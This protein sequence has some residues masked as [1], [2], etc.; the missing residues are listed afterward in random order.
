V[1]YEDYGY[2]NANRSCINQYLTVPLLEVLKD[3]P[4]STIIDLGCGNGWLT[5]LLIDLG[6]NA[7]GTD[8]SPTGIAFAKEKHPDRFALQDLSK[9]ALPAELEGIPFDLILSTEV[10]E[11]LYSPKKYI[12]FCKTLLSRNGGGTVVLSTP[13]HGYWK[14]LVLSVAGTMDDHFTA[15]WEGGHVKFWSRRTLTK[16][17]ESQGFQVT[18]FKGCGRLPYLWKSMIL[19]AEYPGAQQVHH[20]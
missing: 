9:N 6:Y 7:Y 13:Y 15:L 8:A 3:K 20:R 11:H 18:K 16:L 1:D 4:K 10:I 19:R 14:N 5:N 17:L 12:E 2:R